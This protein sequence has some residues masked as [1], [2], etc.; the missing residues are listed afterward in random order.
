MADRND[1]IKRIISRF[2][3]NLELRG[4]KVNRLILYGSHARGKAKPYSD[5]D[6]AVISP[7]FRGKGLLKRQELLGE[8]IFA[9]DAPIEALGYTTKEYRNC[10]PLSFLSE[11]LSTGKL[12]YRKQ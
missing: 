9:T 2:V 1:S 10:P 7:G 5:I 12:V 8:I 6:I 11:I 4:I 3:T